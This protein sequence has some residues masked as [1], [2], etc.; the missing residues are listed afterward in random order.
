MII[1]RAVPGR[2]Y[3]FLL[4]IIKYFAVKGGCLWFRRFRPIACSL[5][6]GMSTF[7]M[8]RKHW[9]CLL[10]IKDLAWEDNDLWSMRF[11]VLCCVSENACIG[12]KLKWA[13]KNCNK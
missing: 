5:S 3:L 10:K 2:S 8:L 6:C 13:Y 12:R 11:A 9:E 1:Q 7:Q 4:Q